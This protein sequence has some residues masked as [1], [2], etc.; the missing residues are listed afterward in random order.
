M[1]FE[2]AN[3][4]DGAERAKRRVAKMSERE[5][6]DWLDGALMGMAH[7]LDE[8]RRSGEIAHLGEMAIGDMSVGVVLT[9]LIRCAQAKQEEGLTG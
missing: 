5:L 9:E 4:D 3:A 1:I 2:G 8:Y 6:L 7:H